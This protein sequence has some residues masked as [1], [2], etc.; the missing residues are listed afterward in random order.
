[1]RVTALY[2]SVS[3]GFD[4]AIVFGLILD[5]MLIS[6]EAHHRFMALSNHHLFFIFSLTGIK[7]FVSR[8]I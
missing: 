7:S 2:V 6:N 3:V 1:M 5:L 4:L 8:K